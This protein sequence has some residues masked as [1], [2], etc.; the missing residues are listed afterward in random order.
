MGWEHRTAPVVVNSAVWNGETSP[1]SSLSPLALAEEEPAGIGDVW[2]L[3]GGKASN[4]L[5]LKINYHVFISDHPTS[6]SLGL[7]S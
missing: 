6:D 7:Q 2:D 3:L 1:A 4:S 5:V